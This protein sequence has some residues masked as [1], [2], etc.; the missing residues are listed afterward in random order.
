VQFFCCRAPLEKRLSMRDRL[1]RQLLLQTKDAFFARPACSLNGLDWQTATAWQARMV[2]AVVE[3]DGTA[4]L[5]T[6]RAV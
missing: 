6:L 3:L 4:T 2:L 5:F 1:A